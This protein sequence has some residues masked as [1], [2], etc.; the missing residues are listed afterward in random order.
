PLG[1]LPANL[2]AIPAVAPATVLGLCAAAIAPWS[3]AAASAVARAAAPFAGW[4]LRV[5]EVFGGPGWALAV[6]SMLGIVLAVPVVVAAV[7]R[8]TKLSQPPR[9]LGEDE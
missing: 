5:G 7:R 2:L 9:K 1:G 6:P 4:V 3:E 8:L